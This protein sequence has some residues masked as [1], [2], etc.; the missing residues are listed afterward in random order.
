MAHFLVLHTWDPRVGSSEK[1]M[2]IMKGALD[3]FTGDTYCITSYMSIGAGKVACLWEGPSEQAII[4][5]LAKAPDLPVDG[6]YPTTVVDWAEMKK[7]L[8]TA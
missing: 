2:G 1:Q 8:S 4:D 6:I 5:V 3:A 7:T